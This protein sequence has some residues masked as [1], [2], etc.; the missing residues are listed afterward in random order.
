MKKFGLKILLGFLITFLIA[1]IIIL[2]TI[3]FR[4]DH[5]KK[6][7]PEPRLVSHDTKVKLAELQQ[8]NELT[9]NSI[10]SRTVNYPE[11][12]ITYLIDPETNSAIYYTSFSEINPILIKTLLASEDQ[13][14]FVHDGV[15]WYSNLYCFT[16]YISRQGICGASTITQQVARNG[17]LQE[18][19][20]QEAYTRVGFLPTFDR[21]LREIAMA[22]ELEE[23][24]SKTEILEEYINASPFGSTV[25][26]F[27]QAA[28]RYKQTS[29]QIIS[30][31]DAIELV[32]LLQAPSVLNPLINQDPEAEEYLKIRKEYVINSLESFEESPYLF[33]DHI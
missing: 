27:E 8:Q 6:N 31:E 20:G 17:I 22:Q 32:A 7:L 10:T 18:T 2:S 4:I 5:H 26:G 30:E 21:K 33:E 25:Y 13:K 29:I 11:K 3:F 1:S 19:Y 12:D 15:D 28:N 16:L 24:F 23:K 14:F 9:P